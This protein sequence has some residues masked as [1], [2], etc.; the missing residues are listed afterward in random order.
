MLNCMCYVLMDTVVKSLHTRL[1]WIEESITCSM[2]IL[3]PQPFD[4]EVMAATLTT[5][6]LSQCHAVVTG[7]RLSSLPNAPLHTIMSFLT[8]RQAVKTC[9]LSRRWTDLWCSMP[10]LD[11]DQ[12]E[13]DA[14]ASPARE[15]RE[16]AWDRFEKFVNTLLNCHRAQSL[17]IFRFH[18]TSSEFKIVDQWLR[19]GIKGSPAVLEI[20]LSCHSIF[21]G[22]PHYGSSYCRLERLRLVGVALGTSLTQ[23]LCS[24]CPALKDLELESCL[25][26]SSEVASRTLKNLTIRD[27]GTYSGNV[28]SVKAPALTSFHLVI[29]VA[30]FK[31]SGIVVD[32]MLCLQIVN[33]FQ[34]CLWD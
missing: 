34:I 15:D 27:C 1:L 4:A 26:D 11:I 29:T 2:C 33:L 19:R 23:Q 9:V 16:R 21:H 7:D 32:E 8:S 10:C 6:S 31:W 24:S 3:M 22:L 12:R 20:S 25:L 18:V 17:D 30:G 13:F 5:G 14:K 28:V